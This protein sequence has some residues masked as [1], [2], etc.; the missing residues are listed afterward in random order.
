MRSRSLRHVG[1]YQALWGDELADRQE[2]HRIGVLI[3]RLAWNFQPHLATLFQESLENKSQIFLASMPTPSTE[4]IGV[5]MS[6]CPRPTYWLRSTF[7]GQSNLIRQ[8]QVV[9]SHCIGPPRAQCHVSCLANLPAPGSLFNHEL[10]QT[11][12]NTVQ[13]EPAHWR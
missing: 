7:K 4:W 8:D 12:D 6:Y 13:V 9:R 11:H 10:Q 3:L 1:N 2:V 5:S